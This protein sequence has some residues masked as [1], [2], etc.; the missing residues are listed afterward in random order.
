MDNKVLD[1]ISVSDIEALGISSP[2]AHK[3][4]K[5][6]ADI[7]ANYGAATPQTWTHISKHVLHPDLPFSFHQMMFNACYKDFG[8]DPP[9]WSPDL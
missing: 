6:V 7:V 2:L 8:T 1:A 5:D 4:C 3:L 9:A